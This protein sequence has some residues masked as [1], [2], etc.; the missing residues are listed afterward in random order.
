M[1]H[2]TQEMDKSMW[3]L[4]PVS[5][6]K[7]NFGMLKDHFAFVTHGMLVNI[8]AQGYKGWASDHFLI[9]AKLKLL[10]KGWLEVG[11]TVS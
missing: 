9:L 2:S 4:T 6:F 7:I 10:Y 5:S 1:V 8:I 11:F 3:V